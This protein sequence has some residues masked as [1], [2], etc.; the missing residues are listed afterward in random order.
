M[1][2]YQG[3]AIVQVVQIA[4][5]EQVTAAQQIKQ[6]HSCASCVKALAVWQHAHSQTRQDS[7]CCAGAVG[8]PVAQGTASHDMYHIWNM[9]AEFLSHLFAG[10]NRPQT[11]TH[12]PQ[13]AT[14]V[15]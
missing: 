3:A 7:L 8:V 13:G 1:R 15:R 12:T 14:S 6:T 9:F 4:R 2:Q 5:L 11:H 10:H